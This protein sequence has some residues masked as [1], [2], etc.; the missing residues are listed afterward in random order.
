[1][2]ENRL[3]LV[4]DFGKPPQTFSRGGRSSL[5]SVITS[6]AGYG[7]GMNFDWKNVDY[8]AKFLKNIDVFNSYF[9]TDYLKKLMYIGCKAKY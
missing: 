1:M 5:F 3:V 9:K 7:S 4:K 2:H 8:F 6:M